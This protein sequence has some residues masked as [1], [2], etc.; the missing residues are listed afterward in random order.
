MYIRGAP[1]KGGRSNCESMEFHYAKIT[2]ST[3]QSVILFDWFN[4]LS[5]T[6]KIGIRC[7]IHLFWLARAR[8][9][10]SL[11][12]VYDRLYARHWH[13]Q[14]WILSISPLFDDLYKLL[15]RPAWYILVCKVSPWALIC[16]SSCIQE[17]FTNIT[18]CLLLSL[19]SSL[20]SGPLFP[21]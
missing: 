10:F 14:C 19:N 11:S 9:T 2:L 4:I 15:P 21:E 12:L 8:Y 20:F 6:H 17:T 5:T 3:L 13:S 1:I 18:S 7:K 16:A